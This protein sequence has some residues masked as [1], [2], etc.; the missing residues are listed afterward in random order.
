MLFLSYLIEQ[1][2]VQEKGYAPSSGGR[3]PLI[4]ALNRE[5]LYVV[6]VAMD[7]ISTRIGI[8]NLYNEFVSKVEVKE[9][10]LKDN[11]AALDTLTD[12]IAAHIDQSG[13][14][15]KQ[16]IGVGIGMPGFVSS[17]RGLNYTYL[18]QGEANISAQ[19]SAR[20]NLPV[21]IDN[22]S[23]LIA[24]SE[25]R[26]GS[27]KAIENALVVNFSWGI[28][29]GMIINGQIYRGASGFAGEFSHIPIADEGSLCVCGKQGCL[30]AEASLL[31]LA[32]K[33]V[34][35]KKEGRKSKLIFDDQ[36]STISIAEGIMESAIAGD[37]YAIELLS[38]VGLKIGKGLSILIHIINPKTII[39]SGKGAKIGKFLVPPI[40]QALNVYC[41]ARLVNETQI[42][43]SEIGFDAELVGSAILVME[44]FKPKGK[45]QIASSEPELLAVEG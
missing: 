38:E 37:Q 40:Q 10:Q 19:I 36:D 41:S 13:I 28:G 3:R 32:T 39:I 18:G 9:L 44:S 14:A 45:K 34:K 5:K 16:L 8:V 7:Q 24:L 21:F 31:A 23:S 25:L 29:L 43:I 15:K 4:Y 30:E 35:G 22:D 6:T 26:F 33:A 42:L 11:P 2:F 20:I 17:E 1:D 12:L 27:A